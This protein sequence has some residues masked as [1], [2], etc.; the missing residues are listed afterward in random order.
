ME[1]KTVILYK[2]DLFH[3]IQSKYNLI[4]QKKSLLI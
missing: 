3:S 1:R 2:K 4:E